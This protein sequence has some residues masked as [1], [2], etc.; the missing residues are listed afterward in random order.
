MKGLN[1]KFIMETERSVGRGGGDIP[2][3]EPIT[4]FLSSGTF[5]SFILHHHQW[6]RRALSELIQNNRLLQLM[7]FVVQEASIKTEA[8]RTKQRCAKN[9]CSLES[10]SVSF[11]CTPASWIKHATVAA[12]RLSSSSSCWRSAGIAHAPHRGRA[13]PKLA[14]GC[15]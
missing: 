9:I 2:S 5:P 8:S 13:N 15:C 4:Y 12:C 6:Q 1:I 7:S 11:A 14:S 3:P 10:T